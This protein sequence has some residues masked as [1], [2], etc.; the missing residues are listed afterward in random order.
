MTAIGVEA[1]KFLGM[2][3]IFAQIFPNLPKML[4]WNFAGRFCV[5][6]SKNGFHLFFCEPWSP[7]FEVKQCRAPFLPKFSRILP[8]FS[9]YQNIWGA[10]APPPPTPLMTVI[11][12]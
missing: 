7:F 1:S 5:V 6:T 11:T 12:Y 4:S 9:T 8:G 2:Q 3:R 10:P